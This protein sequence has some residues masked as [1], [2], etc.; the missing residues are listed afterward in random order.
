MERATESKKSMI[1]N[2]MDNVQLVRSRPDFDLYPQMPFNQIEL[3][4]K[5]AARKEQ[6]VT[7]QLNPSPFT[8]T[9]TEVTG[10]ISLSPHS[11]H[12]ILADRYVSTVHLLQPHLIR[13]V[14]LTDNK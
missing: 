14:R 2:L 1:T 8:K 6:E 5:Q 4:I 3:Y 13:H 9:A 10:N 12:V 7:I 11:S